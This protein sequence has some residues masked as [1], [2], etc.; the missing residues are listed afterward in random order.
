AGAATGDGTPS[1]SEDRCWLAW[2]E[3]ASPP[4]ERPDPLYQPTR[5]EA[6]TKIRTLLT[7]RFAHQRA[8][9]GVDFAIG[10]PL[11]SSG[12][13]ILPTG[14]G[15]C[16]HLAEQITDDPSGVSNRFE[17]ADRLNREI[18]E[19]TGADCGPFWGRPKEHTH[20]ADLPIRRPTGPTGVPQFRVAE[21]AAKALMRSSPQSPFKLA[22]IGSVG[23]QSLVGLPMVHRLLTDAD[24]AP[25]VHLWP[26][27]PA[28]E[29][30]NTITIAEIYPSLYP[31]LAPPH[32][33]KDAR[34]VVDTRDA[35][36]AGEV[37]L[38]TPA[39]AQREGWILGVPGEL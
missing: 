17:V 39:I 13:P 20:L 22:G 10:Y 6:E 7:T 18:R 14:R 8:L 23:S 34:Q 37:D 12:E 31:Q 30:P 1:P 35:L 4:T 19:T 26:F 11:A 27:E 36:L 25:R 21:K 33:Y 2:G 28:P 38:M 32:W 15:L 24:L 9:L 29:A 3:R 5:L 16:A